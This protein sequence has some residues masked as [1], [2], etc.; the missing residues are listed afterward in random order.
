MLSF[1][2]ISIR[3]VLEIC[4]E[5]DCATMIWDVANAHIVMRN[6]TINCL[7]LCFIKVFFADLDLSIG[8]NGRV[9]P[10]R[11]DWKR[12]VTNRKMEL[13]NKRKIK[14]EKLDLRVLFV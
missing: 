2:S 3:T 1:G 4:L 6:I 8:W 7:D 5:L 13:E 14:K 12:I 10:L 9:N 11:T